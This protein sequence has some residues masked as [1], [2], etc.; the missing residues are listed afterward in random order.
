MMYFAPL[1]RAVKLDDTD[2]EVGAKVKT[3]EVLLLGSLWNVMVF[4]WLTPV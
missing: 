3:G 2:E 4:T 1:N